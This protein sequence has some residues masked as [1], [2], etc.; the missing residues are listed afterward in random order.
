MPSW[1]NSPL[2]VPLGPVV[3]RISRDVA[4]ATFPGKFS[5][6]DLDDWIADASLVTN[7]PPALLFR[8]TAASLLPPT[9]AATEDKA[10]E[11][12]DPNILLTVKR[13][14]CFPNVPTGTCQKLS[15]VSVH[16]AERPLRQGHDI[17]P[18]PRLKTA[19]DERPAAGTAV[20]V[21]MVD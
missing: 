8:A 12:S 17:V 13:T 19:E 7:Q 4:A 11:N 16:C 20:A 18:R 10:K 1:L 14:L 21:G 6:V 9:I 5:D 3:D 15:D 2:A